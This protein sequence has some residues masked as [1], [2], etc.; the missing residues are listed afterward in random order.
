MAVDG[1]L[2]VFSGPT[3]AVETFM[4]Q[5]DHGLEPAARTAWPAPEKLQQVA[6]LTRFGGTSGFKLVEQPMPNAR[7][8]EI[9]VRVLATSVQFSDVV[10]RKAGGSE[11]GQRAPLVLGYD[12]VGEIDQ[13]GAGVRWLNIGD[14]VADLTVTGSYARYRLL[15]ADRVIRVPKGVASAEAAALVLSWVAA[16]Q[17]LHRVAKVRRGQRILVLGAAGSVGQALLSLGKLAGLEM[18]GSAR[19]DH[20]ELIRSLG[21]WP[22]D[23]ATESALRR[24]PSGFDAVF[25]GIGGEGFSSSWVNVRRGGVL[26][27]YGTSPLDGAVPAWKAAWRRLGLHLRSLIPN[28]KRARF[29]SIIAMRKLHPAWYRADLDVL[30]GLLAARAIAPRITETITLGGVA[31]AHRRVE[32]GQLTAKIIICP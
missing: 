25:D 22:L 16:Y 28:G 9:R 4:D 6:L 27:A 8:G 3:L 10:I 17:L 24:I 12:V 32:S 30:L 20:A 14:R 26:A 29:Y 7:A 31:E 2:R 23:Y 11:L 15:E 18:W 5:P 19:A 1:E 21:A 13:L